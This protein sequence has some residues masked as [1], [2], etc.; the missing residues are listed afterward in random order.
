MGDFVFDVGNGLH[1]FE[2][3]GLFG[4][5]NDVPRF[6]VSLNLGFVVHLFAHFA[7]LSE[8]GIAFFLG[9][10]F[11]HTIEI[12]AKENLGFDRLTELVESIFIDRDIDLANDAVVADAR[13]YASLIRA[14]ESISTALDA[15]SAGVALDLCCIDVESAMQSLGEL[16]GREVGEDIV[17]EIFSKFCV[18]K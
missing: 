7:G 3:D 14:A 8:D 15:I 16:E 6:V 11:E 12:S 2:M 1:F 4:L 9:R 10:R 17:S 5:F 18:G 13:Q